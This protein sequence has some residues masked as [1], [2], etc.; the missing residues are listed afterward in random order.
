MTSREEIS[1]RMKDDGIRYLLTQFVDLNGSPK[2]KMVPVEHFEDVLDE[3]AR[4][5]RRCR[6]RHGPG[7][8]FPRHDG[9]H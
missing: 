2:V 8:A 6:H 7:P 9:S 1:Q 3:G 5:R 4:V